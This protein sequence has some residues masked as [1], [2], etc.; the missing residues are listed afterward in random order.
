SFAPPGA[1]QYQIGLR[2]R[3]LTG[4]WCKRGVVR[5]RRTHFL[6]V[7]SALFQRLNKTRHAADLKTHD[8]A[9]P[10]DVCSPVATIYVH[11]SVGSESRNDPSSPARLTNL[12]M[13]LERIGSGVGSRKH[14]DLEA[15]IESSRV[16]LRSRQLRDNLIVDRLR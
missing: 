15:F 11:H 3:Q 1:V 9:Q 2:I 4:V 8:V 10:L 16:E 13:M 12:S 7:R 5:R 6:E 14:F